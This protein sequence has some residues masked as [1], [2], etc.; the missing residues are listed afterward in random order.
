MEGLP[1]ALVL[2]FPGK[3]PWLSG[4]YTSYLEAG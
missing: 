4:Q 3:A 1:P 2:V